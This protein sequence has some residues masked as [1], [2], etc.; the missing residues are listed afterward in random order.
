MIQAITSGTA[1]KWTC[2]WD[3]LA[4]AGLPRNGVTNRPY[5]GINLLILG[6]DE[7]AIATG[8][9]RW[10]TYK[11]ADGEGWQVR[12]G[13]KS[14]KI[15]L[16]KEI[17]VNDDEDQEDGTKQVLMFRTFSVF[18]ASQIDGVP[19]WEAPSIT[20][21]APERHAQAEALDHQRQ[22]RKDRPRRHQ[23][24]LQPNNRH[25]SPCQPAKPSEPKT[26]TTAP[27]YTS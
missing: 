23:S 4:I 21:S 11:Q 8:D 20:R 10:M 14:T 12:K 26:A 16:A 18:H 22:R 25:P 6:L 9:P 7:R 17:T 27:S 2:P 15:L 3:A 24:V 13:E 19:T 1:G 5:N